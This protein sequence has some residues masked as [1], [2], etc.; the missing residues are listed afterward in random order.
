MATWHLIRDRDVDSGPSFG[1][2]VSEWTVLREQLFIGG[3]GWRARLGLGVGLE[4]FPTI[5]EDHFA[6]GDRLRRQA[7]PLVR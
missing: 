4:D 1:L 3:R 2:R 6:D 7:V 5:A